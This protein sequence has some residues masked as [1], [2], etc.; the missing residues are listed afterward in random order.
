[1]TNSS[2]NV[3]PYGRVR[4]IAYGSLELCIIIIITIFFSF[5][6]Q[7]NTVISSRKTIFRTKTSMRNL[8]L[9]RAL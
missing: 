1:M 3:K 5:R 4:V 9:K 8:N 7:A 2:P 6:N